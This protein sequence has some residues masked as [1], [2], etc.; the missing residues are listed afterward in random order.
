MKMP[1][2]DSQPHVS[3]FLQELKQGPPE[4]MLCHLYF[5]VKHAWRILASLGS[6]KIYILDPYLL[7]L[8]QGW[9]VLLPNW[10][11]AQDRCWP[12]NERNH[13]GSHF[14]NS[15]TE[16]LKDPSHSPNTCVGGCYIVSFI[17]QPSFPQCQKVGDALFA[18]KSRKL[19]RGHLWLLRVDIYK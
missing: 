11:R 5:N 4:R 12:G 2:D 7:R 9:A 18:G 6:W 19:C 13:R 17:S 3:C 10:C 1:L 15:D 8:H 14:A 16:F